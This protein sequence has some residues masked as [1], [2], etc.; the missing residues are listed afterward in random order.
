MAD[1]VIRSRAVSTADPAKR[2]RVLAKAIADFE[3]SP[4]RF[5]DYGD[6]IAVAIRV[7][8]S[9]DGLAWAKI[10]EAIEIGLA[11][12]RMTREVEDQRAMAD[13]CNP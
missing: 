5:D 1:R 10:E 4:R 11:Q 12:A 13:L 7:T 6:L 9:T 2:I 8:R 3:R